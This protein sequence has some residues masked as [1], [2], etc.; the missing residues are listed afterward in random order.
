MVAHSTHAKIGYLRIID[1]D[2]GWGHLQEK[3]IEGE[4][5]KVLSAL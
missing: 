4:K 1:L 3:K 2:A 5:A